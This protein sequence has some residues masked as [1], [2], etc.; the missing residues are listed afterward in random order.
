MP[1]F[2]GKRVKVRHL[3]RDV[4]VELMS[5]FGGVMR[6]RVPSLQRGFLLGLAMIQAY[7][8]GDFKPWN[9]RSGLGPKPSMLPDPDSEEPDADCRLPEK[10]GEHAWPVD[11]GGRARCG[12]GAERGAPDEFDECQEGPLRSPCEAR[13]R[14]DRRWEALHVDGDVEISPRPP[15]GA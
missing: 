1:Q 5:R 14:P 2:F 11:G 13:Q 3:D 12:C 10:H 9:F 6:C 4:S 7:D 15:A 8:N